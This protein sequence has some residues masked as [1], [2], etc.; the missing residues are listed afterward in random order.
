MSISLKQI[1]GIT[2]GGSP[3]TN[4]DVASNAAIAGSKINPDFGAQDLIAG[5]VTATSINGCLTVDDAGTLSA[6]AVNAGDRLVQLSSTGVFVNYDLNNYVQ[7]QPN[8][9]LLVFSGATT[10]S[11]QAGG[12]VAS[13]GTI[14]SESDSNNYTKIQNQGLVILSS[15]AMS[16]QITNSSA[17]F[18]NG[19]A[20]IDYGGNITATGT[21]TATGGFYGDGAS[22]TGILPSVPMTLGTPGTPDSTATLTVAG[23][24]TIQGNNGGIIPFLECQD[25]SGNVKVSINS[26]GSILVAGITTTGIQS[27]G[28]VYATGSITGSS[29]NFNSVN[30][31]YFF[32]NGSNLT[33][34]PPLTVGNIGTVYAAS[35]NLDD[36]GQASP[37][38]PAPIS[39]AVASI[40]VASINSSAGTYSIVNSTSTTSAFLD[41][42][43]GASGNVYYLVV[44]YA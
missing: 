22:L 7:I 27:N 37:T 28:D 2:G 10:F 3:I 15:G 42:S 36:V 6:A 38:Y 13:V 19:N 5:T 8:S 40:P 1:T 33:N 25:W 11:V 44:G 31:T 35:G 16:C 23:K 4:A 9:I 18:C 34:L 43:V 32:G 30:A 14:I 20:T 41:F 17:S 24:E 12:N 26:D 29:G 21:I 39:P